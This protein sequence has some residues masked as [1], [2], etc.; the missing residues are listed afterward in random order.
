M[1]LKLNT[2]NFTN[3]NYQHVSM[4]DAK[5]VVKPKNILDLKLIDEE[6]NRN[7]TLGELIE[8]K[9]TEIKKLRKDLNELKEDL[10]NKTNRL[11]DIIEALKQETRD[12]GVI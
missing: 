11:L 3:P 1:K 8:E 7:F 12:K 9:D 2:N 10:N 6:T 4:Y 5:N